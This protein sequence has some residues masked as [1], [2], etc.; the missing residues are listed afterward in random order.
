MAAEAIACDVAV[1][2]YGRNPSTGLVAVVALIAGNDVIRC[3]ASC[4]NSVVAGYA[5]PCHCRM[6]HESNRAPCSRSVAVC[7]DLGTRN[8]IHRPYSG[9][10]GA[11]RGVTT[12]TSR[13]RA[14]KR[15]SGMAS[16]TTHIGMCTVKL[17]SGAEMIEWRLCRCSRKGCS[18][19]QVAG[20]K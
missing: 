2:E 17:K 10:H 4:N 19:E 8:M 16:I 5:T 3:L 6:V 20:G 14:L 13:I 18:K 15:A 9:L 1:V 11:N 7:T 12:D